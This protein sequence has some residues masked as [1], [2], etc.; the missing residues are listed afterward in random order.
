MVSPAHDNTYSQRRPVLCVRVHAVADRRH[1]YSLAA[2]SRLLGI[3]SMGRPLRKYRLESVNERDWK[4]VRAIYLD[5]IATGQ[6]T[7]ETTAPDWSAWD[8]NHLSS[9]NSLR[10]FLYARARLRRLFAHQ[11]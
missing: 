6:A 9:T 10:S 7:F 4:A 2:K 11:A 3:E 5:G 1:P 8:R